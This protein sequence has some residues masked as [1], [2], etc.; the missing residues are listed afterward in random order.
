MG[1]I[2]KDIPRTREQGFEELKT[3]IKE[4]E[5]IDEEFSFSL[6]H[7]VEGSTASHEASM[8]TGK[9]ADSA[10][11]LD[12]LHEITDSIIGASVIEDEEPPVEVRP[13]ALSDN[14]RKLSRGNKNIDHPL[15]RA[16]KNCEVMCSTP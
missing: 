4:E 11:E 10:Q 5:N 2:F 3:D 7:K 15:Q 6:H 9:S 16:L 12:T 8:K 14:Q 1:E 13:T